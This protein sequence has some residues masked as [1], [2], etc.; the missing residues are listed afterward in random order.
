MIR[1]FLAWLG[2]GMSRVNFFSI[3]SSIELATGHCQISPLTIASTFAD[4]DNADF[5]SVK[6]P[7]GVLEN[8]LIKVKNFIIPIDFIIL[9]MEEDIE[10]PIILGRPFLAT[11]GAVIDVKNGRLTLKVGEEEVEFNLFDAIKYPSFTDTAF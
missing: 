8:V 3:M 11:T 2:G 10:I 6:H 1:S 4:F 7:V 5:R 9:E